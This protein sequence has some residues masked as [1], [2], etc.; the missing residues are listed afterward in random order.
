MSAVSRESVDLV[1][2][3][4]DEACAALASRLRARFTEAETGL[5]TLVEGVPGPR[6]G[7]DP[8]YL[9]Y[10][11]SLVE[12]RPAVLEYAVGVIELGEHRAPDVPAPVLRAA[13]LAARSGVPLDAVLRRYSAGNAFCTDILVEEAEAAGVSAP[14]LRRLLH[15]QATLFDRLLEVVSEEHAEEVASRPA[16]TAERRHAYIEDLLAGRQPGGEVELGYD[17]H[18]HH[19]GLMAKGEGAPL[20]MRE[21]AKQLDRRLLA[22]LH[23][24]DRAVWACWLGGREPLRTEEVVRALAEMPSAPIVFSLGEPGEGIPDWRLTHRQAKAALPIAER[25]E[26]PL[27]RYADVAVLAS[28]LRDDLGATSLRKLYLEP[29]EGMRDGGKAARETLR[30]YFA[31][32]RNVSSTAAAL[33]VDRRTVTNRIRAIEKLFG[34]PLGDFATDLETALRLAD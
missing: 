12:N 10:L 31:T 7:V 20:A 8:A 9:E 26:Q 24:G 34:R 13:R 21:L 25:R 11:D 15:R 32:E 19:V 2:G 3:E 16:T 18:G 1:A 30:A 33:G 27:L 6:D 28:I 17:L 5:A 22:D 23:D 29:L 14:D 4:F